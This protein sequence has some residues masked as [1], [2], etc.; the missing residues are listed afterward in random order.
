MLCVYF[1]ML[2]SKLAAFHPGHFHCILG[3]D[4]R[5]FCGAR[6]TGGY[7]ITMHNGIVRML[8]EG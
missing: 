8:L 5:D 7:G 3:V 2:N 6:F 4:T 1:V